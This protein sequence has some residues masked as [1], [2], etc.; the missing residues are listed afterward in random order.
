[1]KDAMDFLVGGQIMNAEEPATGFN[2]VALV[3]RAGRNP[4][5]NMVL[6]GVPSTCFRTSKQRGENVVRVLCS[7]FFDRV[8]YF[9][10]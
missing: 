3:V 6:R 7:C 9:E 10:R 2:V 1:M 5:T 8:H 4:R